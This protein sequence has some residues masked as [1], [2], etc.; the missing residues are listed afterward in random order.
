MLLY[1]SITTSLFAYSQQNKTALALAIGQSDE[2]IAE[3]VIRAAIK[4]DMTDV[5]E[6]LVASDHYRVKALTVSIEEGKP[7]MIKH[8]VEKGVVRAENKVWQ[9][10]YD[11]IT[12]VTKAIAQLIAT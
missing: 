11:I 4:R 12:R 10:V 2:D 7:D 1:D 9:T 8:L 3:L 5:A 6:L